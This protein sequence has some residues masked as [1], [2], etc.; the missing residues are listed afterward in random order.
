M[1]S[2]GAPIPMTSRA[3]GALTGTAQVP[4]DKS[5]SHRSLI[6]GAMSVGETTI[7]G[8]LEGQDVLDTARAMRAFGA[9]VTDHGGGSWSVYGVGVGG[10]AEPDQV[11]DCGNSGTGVR[12]IMGCMATSPIS[13]TFTGDAS[14]NGRPMARVTDP[15]ALFGTQSVGRSGG[16][17][18]MTIVGAAEPVPVRYVVP[19]PSAQVKSAV[20]L[21]GLNAPGKTVV[22]E[23]EAT[24]DHTERMLA[25][26]GAEITTEITDEGRVITLTGQPELKAQHIDVPRDPSSAAFPVCAA[27]IVPSSD[28]LVPNIGLNQTRAGLF[29]TLREM[30]ADLTYENEREEGGEPVADLRARFSPDLKGIEVPAERAASMIDEYPVLSVV[31][32]F[33]S[34]KT[35]MPGVKELRVKESDRIDAMKVGLEAN[36]I[37]VEDGPDWWTVTGLGHGNVPG[38]ATCASHLD[39]R[40]AMSFLVLGMATQRPV[41]VDDGGP[42]ATSFPIFEPLMGGLGAAI[43]RSNG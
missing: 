14:L 29:T 32:A 18:P 26:F 10:F 37:T 1:S 5:I 16:R 19:V 17:L 27:L 35:H 12:L 8:L 9:E 41:S 22:I 25:G 34:G 43:T 38:G 42:I 40:I 39:H 23:T 30:G 2:H 31:A 4:G 15:L 33:A 20:L 11:I 28:V 7:T 21:A 3:C 24:R 13:A 36:G 6:L